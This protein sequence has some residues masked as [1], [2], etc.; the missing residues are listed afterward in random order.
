[1]GGICHAEYVGKEPGWPTKFRWR[2]APANQTAATA[3]ES[4]HF[5][6]DLAKYTTSSSEIEFTVRLVTKKIKIN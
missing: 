2:M 1:M 5:E 4:F 3:K 6:I